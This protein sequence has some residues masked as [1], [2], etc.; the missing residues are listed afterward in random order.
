MFRALYG[1]LPRVSWGEILGIGSVGCN[2]KQDP[3]PNS[4]AR[5]APDRLRKREDLGETEK[6]DDVTT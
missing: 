1:L 6:F 4:P 5:A 2:T 3:R